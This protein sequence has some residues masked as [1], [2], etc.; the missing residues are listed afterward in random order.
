MELIEFLTVHID[1]VDRLT[2]A[3][4]ISLIV[5]Q[6]LDIYLQFEKK[7]GGKMERYEEV[8]EEMGLSLPTVRR[9]VRE[10]KKVVLI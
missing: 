10:M 9:A 8:A 3:G 6:E 7:T 5:K 1:V 4:K 2:K